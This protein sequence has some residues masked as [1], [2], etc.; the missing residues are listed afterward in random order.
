M[1]GER[2]DKGGIIGSGKVGNEWVEFDVS[3]HNVT[4]EMGDFYVSMYWITAPGK[5]GQNAQFL[6]AESNDIIPGR[7][8]FKFGG[9]GN[10]TFK[11]DVNCIVQ[12]TVNN[13]FLLTCNDE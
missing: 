13:T 8:Y 4:I 6:G 3:K 7:T 10:W 11:N 5:S 9:D 1:P 2:L 12:A